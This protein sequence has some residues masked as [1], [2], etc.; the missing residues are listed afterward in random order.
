MIIIVFFILH[1][2][3]SVFFQSF[4]LHRYAAHGMYKLSPFTE[5]LMYIFTYIAQGSSYLS[6]RAYAIL[7]KAHHSY[8]DTSLD[9]HSPVHAKN[10]FDMMLKT[11][12]VYDKVLKGEHQFNK[13]F[14]ADLHEDWA[15]FDKIAGSWYSRLFIGTLY[16]LFY[17]FFA[18]SAWYFLLLP[19]HYL[20]GPLHGLIVNWCGHK[21]GYRNYKSVD[22]S[23]NTLAIDFLMVGEL[24]QNNHHQEPNNINFARKWWEVDPTYLVYKFACILNP[25]TSSKTSSKNKLTEISTDSLEPISQKI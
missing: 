11:A 15:S 17:I 16:T 8:S 18:P 25:F 10:P 12:L 5:K 20:M 19:I 13:Q 14:K 21:Y 24:F 7:H 6:P 3:L 2:Y 23:K 4:F 9:P 22:D 1:W